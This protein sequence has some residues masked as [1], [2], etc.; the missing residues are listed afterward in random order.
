[1]TCS[2]SKGFP[3]EKAVYHCVKQIGEGGNGTVHIAQPVDVK[4]PEIGVD[5]RYALKLF[6]VPSDRKYFQRRKKRFIREIQT[7]LEIQDQIKGIVPILDHSDL[8]DDSPE[9]WYVMPLGE[10]YRYQ[11][12][13]SLSEILMEIHVIAETVKSL[14]DYG[15]YH[16]DQLFLLCINGYN[17]ISCIQKLLSLFVYEVELRISVRMRFFYLQIFLIL[18]FT[19]A[20]IIQCSADN[21]LRYCNTKLYR[22]NI[23]GENS[24]FF[25]TFRLEC[26]ALK[27]AI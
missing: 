27:G 9:L 7:V 18:L 6:A 3:G 22:A 11:D 8:S 17:R 16:R 26:Y 14:H 23:F 13:R 19:V 15:K 25:R 12:E 2:E 10:K 5:R 20:K 1:M 4:N 24:H 21:I